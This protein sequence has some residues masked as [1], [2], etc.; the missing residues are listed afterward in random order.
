MNKD[1]NSSYLLAWPHSDLLNLL[2]KGREI[3]KI[4][5]NRVMSVLT[6]GKCTNHSLCY[7]PF[8]KYESFIN[9]TNLVFGV[10]KGNEKFNFWNVNR[11]ILKNNWHFIV[12]IIIDAKGLSSDI[13]NLVGIYGI[14]LTRSVI[15]AYNFG[16]ENLCTDL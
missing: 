15:V 13:I 3:D 14:K 1:K 4:L 11:L 5:V 9:D 8:E 2:N 16:K 6:S 10:T 7:R 12:A